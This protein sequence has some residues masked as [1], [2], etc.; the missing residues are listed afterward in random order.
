MAGIHQDKPRKVIPLWKPFSESAA[1]GELSS[2]RGERGSELSTIYFEH[3]LLE[4]RTEH[5]LVAAVDVVHAAVVLGVRSEAIDAARF[6]VDHLPNKQSAAMQLAEG[7]LDK[8]PRAPSQSHRILKVEHTHERIARLKRQT[9]IFPESPFV[10]VDL[11]RSYATIGHSHKARRAMMCALSL[12]PANRFVVRC[13]V[14]FLIHQDEFGAAHDI[15]RRIAKDNAD[16]WLLAAEI[17]SSSAAGKTSQNVKRARRLIDASSF[18]PFDTSEL[19][20][21]L[22]T[23]ELEAGKVKQ[24][25]KLFLLSLQDP[26]QN[27]VAQAIW[28]APK[29]S[30]SEM[31]FPEENDWPDSGEAFAMGYRRVGKW[32]EAIEATKRWQQEQPFSSRPAELG[33]YLAGLV[34]GS[35]EDA[36]AFAQTGLLAN[37]DNFTIRNNLAFSL[38]KLD[39]NEEARKAL[40]PL[41]KSELTVSEVPVW[42]ATRGLIA[43]RAGD[44]PEGQRLYQEAIQLMKDDPAR[45]AFARMYWALEEIRAGTDSAHVLASEALAEAR[46]QKDKEMIFLVKRLERDLNP[47]TFTDGDHT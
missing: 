34:A 30:H 27:S 31:Q 23:L 16:P 8:T 5:T 41:K 32:G 6:V 15:V 11:A 40:A 43:F 24:G 19:A 14:R 18:F 36:V 3:S 29:F 46:R 28:A 42:Y 1:H 37:P 22:G 4:W 47:G 13:A 20:S 7:L 21:A 38:A 17:A 25:R 45:Q 44:T 26:T 12:A 39:R 10:W 35:M 9:V 33:S 2:L